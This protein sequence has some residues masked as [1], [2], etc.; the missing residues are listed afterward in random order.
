LT[1][2]G[3]RGSDR[4]MEAM[5]LAGGMGTRLRPVLGEKQKVIAEIDGR[6]FLG[7]LLDRLADAGAE[8][9]VLCTGFKAD[10]VESV[11]GMEHRGMSLLY[12]R[13]EAPMGTGG[14]VRKALDEIHG[15][16]FFVL[17]GDSFC[18][19]NLRALLE[20]HRMR[21]A[22]AT[23]TLVRVSDTAR[24]G[25]VEQSAQGAIMAFVEKGVSA[26]PGWINAGVYCLERG[27]VLG[28]PPG[29]VLSLEREVFPTWIGRGFY[30]YCCDGGFLDIGTPE[31]HAAAAGFFAGLRSENP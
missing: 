28:L 4:A 30:G 13:E 27:A 17:N 1:G 22:Q 18:D 15:E 7:H 10:D 20:H 3:G 31:S 2:S 11:L 25:R 23:L 12:S 8:R 9:T 29:C 14:A 5:I 24:F 16:T 6:P 26:G 21:E 19:V